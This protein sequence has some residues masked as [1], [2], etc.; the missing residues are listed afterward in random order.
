MSRPNEKLIFVILLISLFACSTAPGQQNAALP[1][2]ITA[3]SEPMVTVP[4]FELSAPAEAKDGNYLGVSDAGSFKS[5]EIKADIL[6]VEVFSMYCPHC[7]RE[8]PQVNELF[9]AIEQDLSLK[10]R[11]KII[12]IG[13][14]NSA[15][16]VDVFKKKYE[17]AF[18]L[19]PDQKFNIT[20]LLKV[21]T[22]PTFVGLRTKSGGDYE[23]ILFHVGALGDVESFLHT[24]KTQLAR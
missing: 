14:G 9:E 7:Q 18:P 16:E 6:L 19:F 11:V 3:P 2:P 1:L 21:G 12:G 23:Q 5:T 13:A 20:S 22:T 17:I 15:Y 8:A 10:E 4:V 24:V